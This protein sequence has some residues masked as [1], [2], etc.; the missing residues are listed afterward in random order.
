MALTGYRDFDEEGFYF[1]LVE[2]LRAEPQELL[3]YSGRGLERVATTLTVF[4]GLF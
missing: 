3:M 4:E 1:P 2:T